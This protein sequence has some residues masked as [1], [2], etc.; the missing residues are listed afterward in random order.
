MGTNSISDEDFMK[1]YVRH[2]KSES[3]S[4]KYVKEKGRGSIKI[5]Y[6]VFLAL[7]FILV[8]YL[9]SEFYFIPK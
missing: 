2:N 9:F 4:D 5:G 7:V 3:R 1:N 6:W 8:Y